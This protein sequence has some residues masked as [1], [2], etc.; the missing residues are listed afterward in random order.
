MFKSKRELKSSEDEDEDAE[1]VINEKDE[2]ELDDHEKH[3]ENLVFGVYI[4]I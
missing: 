2:E 4:D 1:I 3:L